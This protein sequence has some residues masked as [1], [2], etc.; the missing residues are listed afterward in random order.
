MIYIQNPEELKDMMELPN[1][2]KS[3]ELE[4]LIY[5]KERKILRFGGDYE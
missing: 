1:D 3:S 2:K 5:E 4:D